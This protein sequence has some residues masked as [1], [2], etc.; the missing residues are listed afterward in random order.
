MVRHIGGTSWPGRLTLTNYALYFEA[1]GTLSYEEALKINLLQNMEQSVKPAA[2]GPF[3]APLFDKAMIYEC[4]EMPE[5]VVFEFPEII[6]STRRDHWLSLTKEIILLHRF[7][8]ENKV[9]ASLQA[10]EIHAWT[11]L[12]IVRLHAAREMLRMAPPVLKSFLIF[13]L[14]DELPKGGYV[15]EELAWGLQQADCSNPCSASS[16]LRSLNMPHGFSGIADLHEDDDGSQVLRQMED[17]QT[18][19]N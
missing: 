16:I 19:L 12:A 8:S 5:G 13:T 11:I 14:M 10:W 9:E 4:S 7:L 1:S 15:L 17:S 18:L 6:S 3:G 2:T